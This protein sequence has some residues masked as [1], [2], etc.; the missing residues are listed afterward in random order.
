[1]ARHFFDALGRQRRDR[2]R[3]AILMGLAMRTVQRLDRAAA[4]FIDLAGW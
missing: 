4:D 1:M 3:Y 2:A